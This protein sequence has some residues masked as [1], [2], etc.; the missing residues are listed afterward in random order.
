MALRDV[1]LIS[2]DREQLGSIVWWPSEKTASDKLFDLVSMENWCSSLILCCRYHPLTLLRVLFPRLAPNG[3]LVI[4]GHDL[5]SLADCYHF[6]KLTG[7]AINIHLSDTFLRDYQI[8]PNRTHPY[9]HMTSSGLIL[10]AIKLAPN[11]STPLVAH[12]D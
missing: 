1:T 5:T 6:L 4:Y 10:T 2:K 8:L 12:S 7:L 11:H 3:H 9:L